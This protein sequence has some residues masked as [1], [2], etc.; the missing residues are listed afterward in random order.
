MYHLD[1]SEIPLNQPLPNLST[2]VNLYYLNLNNTQLTG[3]IN[4][5]YFPSSL[6][7]LYLNSNQLQGSIPDFSKLTELYWL[8]LYNNQLTGTIP[9]FTA[10]SQL[11]YLNLSSNQLTGSIPNFPTNLGY[12]YLNNNQLSGDIP[13]SFTELKNICSQCPE[14][15]DLCGSCLDLSYNYLNIFV[16]P[17]VFAFLEAPGNKDPDWAVLGLNL[18]LENLTLVPPSLT[19]QLPSRLTHALKIVVISNSKMLNSLALTK[20]NLPGNVI[21]NQNAIFKKITVTKVDGTI[22]IILPANLL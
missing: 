1:L 7:E 9:D 16:S 17:E 12:L 11:W 8:G 22:I 21:L 15:P 14:Q 13:L 2:L 18:I 6:R 10:L 19:T 20:M 3:E 5:N 4:Q